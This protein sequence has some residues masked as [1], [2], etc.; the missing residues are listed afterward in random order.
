M[1]THLVIQLV[2][3]SAQNVILNLGDVTVYGAK[4]GDGGHW[5]RGI[6]DAAG[7]T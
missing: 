3:V 2:G 4:G 5:A 7:G 1:G 6:G